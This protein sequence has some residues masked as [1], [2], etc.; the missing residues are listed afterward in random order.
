MR[1]SPPSKHIPMMASTVWYFARRR[2][3]YTNLEIVCGKYTS[4]KHVRFGKKKKQTGKPFRIKGYCA[5]LRSERIYRIDSH[6]QDTWRIDQQEP[7]LAG[8]TGAHI[9]N[10]ISCEKFSGSSWLLLPSLHRHPSCLASKVLLPWYSQCQT[11]TLLKQLCPN[12]NASP[13]TTVLH[14]PQFL[15]AVNWQQKPCWLVTFPSGW[16]Q[17]WP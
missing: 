5:K 12:D 10:D 2:H 16:C 3:V 9:T 4:W 13:S 17:M 1:L 7:A 14:R 6:L 8:A 15:Y 11:H